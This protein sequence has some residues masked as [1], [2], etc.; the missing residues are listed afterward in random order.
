MNIPNYAGR[1]LIIDG[2]YN[3]SVQKQKDMANRDFLSNYLEQVTNITGMTL[4]FPPIA[5]SFPFAGETNRLIEKLDKEGLCE[6]SE[7]FK[8]FKQHIYNRNTYGGGVSAVAVWVESHCTLHSWTEK[9]YIS[10]DLFSCSSYE[11]QPVIDY[12]I[13]ALGLIKSSFVVVDRMMD[14]SAPRI[15]KFSQ[16]EWVKSQEILKQAKAN[17]IFT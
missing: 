13:E 8:E 7:I 17:L 10:V 12:S 5:M 1:H 2:V 14:G 9:N 16:E 11:I 4:V 15:E 6:N 3:T